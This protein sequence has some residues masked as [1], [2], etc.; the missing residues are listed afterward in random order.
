MYKKPNNPRIELLT[1][2]YKDRAFNL[3]SIKLLD[4]LV[5]CCVWCL[6][7]LKGMQRRWCGV[8]GRMFSGGN[9]LGQTTERTRIVRFII[10][11][12]LQV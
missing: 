9:G 2:S 3:S 12:G 5:K 6:Q 8:E 11:A 4:G 1:K 7:P 10:Q